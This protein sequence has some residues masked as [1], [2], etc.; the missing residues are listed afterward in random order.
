MLSSNPEAG[1]VRGYV[2]R[3]LLLKAEFAAFRKRYTFSK[4][5]AIQEFAN[6]INQKVPTHNYGKMYADW[7]H[8]L[9]EGHQNLAWR[10]A[11]FFDE[12][13]LYYLKPDK[14]QTIPFI[15]YISGNGF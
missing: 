14:I 15:H 10:P 8:Y 2:L 11:K 1:K 7:W 9:L 5:L 6:A 3:N 13:P 12:Q 4:I